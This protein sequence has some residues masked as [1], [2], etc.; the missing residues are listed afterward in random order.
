MKTSTSDKN[1][2][3]RAPR[4]AKS[5][6]LHIEHRLQHG[7]KLSEVR[8]QIFQSHRSSKKDILEVWGAMDLNSIQPTDGSSQLKTFAANAM[9]KLLQLFDHGVLAPH[10]GFPGIV[11]PIIRQLAAACA[12]RGQ[13][14]DGFLQIFS[15]RL[16]VVVDRSKPGQDFSGI[17]QIKV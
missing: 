4:L 8:L 13:S 11:A 9:P 10:R 14:C 12:P 15:L 7:L 16:A 3:L 17:L 6:D 2:F 1:A 5:P